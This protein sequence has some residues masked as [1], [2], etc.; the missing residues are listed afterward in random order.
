ARRQAEEKRTRGQRGKRGGAGEGRAWNESMEW[1]IGRTHPPPAP[2]IPGPLFN[3][4]PPL[5]LCAPSA[6]LCLSVAS[7]PSS[8]ASRRS[9]QPCQ[10]LLTCSSFSCSSE[11]GLGARVMRS[12]PI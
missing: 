3:P 1:M 5:H 9:D 8:H 10:V 2:S 6:S 11:T 12:A 4:H 7:L